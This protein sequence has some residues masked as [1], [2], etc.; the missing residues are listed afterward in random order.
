MLNMPVSRVFSDLRCTTGEMY[1]H[2]NV[3]I[4]VLNR[5][6][7][8]Y[9]CCGLVGNMFHF[10]AQLANILKLWMKAG[11]AYK[12]LGFDYFVTAMLNLPARK[13]T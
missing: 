10:D 1:H 13:E 6:V 12:E 5:L 9:P 8:S 11:D 3:P 2:F 4:Q 7:L